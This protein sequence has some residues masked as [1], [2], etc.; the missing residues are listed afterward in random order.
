M[1]RMD[2]RVGDHRHSGRR[3]KVRFALDFVPSQ[4]TATVQTRESRQF[5]KAE[6]ACLSSTAPGHP[7]GRHPLR[8]LPYSFRRLAFVRLAP[9]RVVSISIL[10]YNT[11]TKVGDI[12]GLM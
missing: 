4:R 9:S 1:A 7:L 12:T 3:V 5:F 2:F 8:R 10:D 11:L 6:P